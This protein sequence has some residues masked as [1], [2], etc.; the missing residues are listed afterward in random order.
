MFAIARQGAGAA[1]GAKGAWR[2]TVPPRGNAACRWQRH[3][4]AWRRLAL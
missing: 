4:E 2:A 1:G 3:R